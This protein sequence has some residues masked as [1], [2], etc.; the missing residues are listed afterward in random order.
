[1]DE[2]SL[3]AIGI[4]SNAGVKVVCFILGYKTIKLGY[5]M[6]KDGIK[7]EFNFS[8]DYKG[9]KGGL[10]S[11]SPGL[12]FLLLGVLLIGY[13]MAVKKTV[14]LDSETAPAPSRNERTLPHEPKEEVTDS[15]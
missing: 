8:A 1:M 12:L 9:I 7:G 4:A 5:Q 11:S 13:S 3:T 14:S 15:L 2:Y 6:M 10:V